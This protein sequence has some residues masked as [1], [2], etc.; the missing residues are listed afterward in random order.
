M[1]PKRSVPWVGLAIMAGSMALL[2][3]PRV[4]AGTSSQKVVVKN[5]GNATVRV[6]VFTSEQPACTT[7]HQLFLG[8]VPAG[9]GISLGAPTT[10]VCAEQ[11]YADADDA[12]WSAA[13]RYCRAE[14]CT[15]SGRAK[16][17]APGPDPFIRVQ[18]KETPGK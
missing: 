12:P 8:T 4:D 7:G 3:T 17:C 11:T 10:C 13:Q 1:L 2:T 16:S 6:R 9:E 14:V 18:V 5:T 15:G